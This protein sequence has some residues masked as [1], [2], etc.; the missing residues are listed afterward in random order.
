MRRSEA[1]SLAWRRAPAS[2]IR[3]S[4]GEWWVL[5]QDICVLHLDV[6]LRVVGG[7]GGHRIYGV[8]HGGLLFTSL[9]EFRLNMRMSARPF[10]SMGLCL[11]H[12]T[13][14]LKM[15]RKSKGRLCFVAPSASVLLACV[16]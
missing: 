4:P 13:I 3:V 5:L 14:S 8:T 9:R 16:E 6:T 11:F 10:D 7:E 1:S 12:N 2:G 15:L